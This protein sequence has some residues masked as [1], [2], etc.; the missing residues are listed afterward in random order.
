MGVGPLIGV[1]YENRHTGRPRR[2]LLSY[3]TETLRGDSYTAPEAAEAAA[4]A[5]AA[6]T[7]GCPHTTHNARDVEVPAD[8]RERADEKWLPVIRCLF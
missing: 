5:E 4:E 3:H 8:G 1:W 2:P 6:I 7:H